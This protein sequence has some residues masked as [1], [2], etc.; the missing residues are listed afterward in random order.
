MSA[1]YTE[2]VDDSICNYMYADKLSA[3]CLIGQIVHFH[4]RNL[5]QMHKCQKIHAI[6][7]T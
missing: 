4:V 2:N 1:M 7:I 5:A 3:V 6:I